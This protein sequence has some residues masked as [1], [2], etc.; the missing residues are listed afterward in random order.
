MIADGGGGR[1][2]GKETKEVSIDRLIFIVSS[3]KIFH[4]FSLFSGSSAKLILFQ[5]FFS[6]FF[7][8]S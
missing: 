6:S 4:K 3:Y 2:D 8:I 1:G 7:L 5:Y